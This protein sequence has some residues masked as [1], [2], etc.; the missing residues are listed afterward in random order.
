MH[1]SS[2]SAS[3]LC[4]LT[5]S[6]EL[7][8]GFE[9]RT[10]GGQERHLVCLKAVLHI[11]SETPRPVGMANVLHGHQHNDEKDGNAEMH[12]VEHR[13]LCVS[14]PIGYRGRGAKARGAHLYVHIGT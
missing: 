13:A 7:Y 14:L 10:L 4:S 2:L 11:F 6:A 1:R 8:G 3:F 5:C 9:R 12:T